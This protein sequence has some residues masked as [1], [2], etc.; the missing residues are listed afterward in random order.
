[1]LLLN[2]D[3]MC[4]DIP[5]LWENCPMTTKTSKTQKLYFIEKSDILGKNTVVIYCNLS[6]AVEY[7]AYF[8]PF[9]LPFIH[10]LGA[11]FKNS[12]AEGRMMSWFKTYLPFQCLPVVFFPCKEFLPMEYT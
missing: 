11:S 5:S 8:P 1:M 4:L 10:Y 2:I 6:S 12:E 7:C 9:L 3:S